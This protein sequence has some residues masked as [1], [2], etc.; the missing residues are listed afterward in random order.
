VLP[1]PTTRPE[2]T[3]TTSTQGDFLEPIGFLQSDP[4]SFSGPVDLAFDPS[5]NLY[6]LDSLN[7]R[8]QKFAPDGSFI[9]VWGKFGSADGEFNLIDSN[10]VGLGSIAVDLEGFVYVA[11]TFNSRIQKFDSNGNFLLSWTNLGGDGTKLNRPY[12]VAVDLDTVYVMDDVLNV[13]VAFNSNGEYL[14]VIGQEG[15]GNGEFNNPGFVSVDEQGNIYVADFDNNRIQK[16]DYT[17]QFLATWGT[18]GSG[19]GEFVQPLDVAVDQAGNMYVVDFGNDRI[20]KLDVQGNFL[21]AYGMLGTRAD[22]FN[23]PTAAVIGP[24]GYLYVADYGNNRISI[25]QI[26]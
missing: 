8:V 1:T 4:N 9:K 5:G 25:F 12:G 10:G 11:D 2:P 26:K 14:G 20:Q 18:V 13:L 15:S 24:D 6:V 3:S 16:F 17:G 21:G 7:S 23:Q 19:D 22:K